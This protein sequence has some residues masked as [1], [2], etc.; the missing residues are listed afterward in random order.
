M[1]P[2]IAR[3]GADLVDLLVPFS[4][5][6]AGWASTRLL[7]GSVTLSDCLEIAS[8]ARRANEV[9]LVL[10]SHHHP[11]LE[12]GITRFAE[13]A[14]AA[15]LD[16]IIVPDLQPEDAHAFKD[17]C[18]SVGVDLVLPLVPASSDE[19]L[20][21]V[22]SMATGFI[23]CAA[24]RDPQVSHQGDLG[25]LENLVARARTLTDLPVV[26]DID[27][28]T[29]QEVAAVAS[30]AE[31]VVASSALTQLIGTLTEDDLLLGVSDFI[32]ELKGATAKE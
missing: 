29:P 27:L 17:A 23:Y 26:A 11:I 19:R 13:D 4:G 24:G 1:V 20:E 12:Y 10:T 8:V 25:A 3:Q 7:A 2:V 14:E 15:G 22:T 28:S 6:E 31:G 32:R 5:A 9:P 30:I 16:G 21:K 18:A